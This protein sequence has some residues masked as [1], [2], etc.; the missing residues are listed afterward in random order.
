MSNATM[1]PRRRNGGLAP[2][3]AAALVPP[4]SAPRP[5]RRARQRRRAGPR[6]GP[7]RLSRPT[8]DVPPSGSRNRTA[9]RVPGR[10]HGDQNVIVTE[11]A[12][13][14]AASACC[15]ADPSVES[16]SEPGHGITTAQ[17][18]TAAPGRSR[19]SSRRA[20]A[21][22]SVNGPMTTQLGDPEFAVSGAH[23]DVRRT[24]NIHMQN[25]SGPAAVAERAGPTQVAGADVTS[26]TV[27]AISVAKRMIESST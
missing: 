3:P 17:E 12:S 14:A 25:P 15:W 9:P 6:R 16:G 7:D 24:D 10:G 5:V 27:G 1:R 13:I 21:P 18:V 22:T 2:R 11:R 19:E 4:R 26:R 8:R 23:A 20:S